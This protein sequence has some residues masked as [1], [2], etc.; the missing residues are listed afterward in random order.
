M[1]LKMGFEVRWVDFVMRCVSSVSF[2]VLLNV[3]QYGLIAPTRGL[4]QGDLLSPYLFLICSKGLLS[5]FKHAIS[6]GDLC[7]LQ[8]APQSIILSHLYFVDDTIPFTLA[9][10]HD[11]QVIL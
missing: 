5:L 2:P 3:T 11:S 4:G 10:Q 6:V 9:T 1:M 8:V 7:G